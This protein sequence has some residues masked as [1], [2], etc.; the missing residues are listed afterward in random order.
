ML[1]YEWIHKYFCYIYCLNHKNR[2]TRELCQESSYFT[3]QAKPGSSS[4]AAPNWILLL[5]KQ[6]IK[7]S[8]VSTNRNYRSNV[9][10]LTISLGREQQI[11]LGKET[12]MTQTVQLRSGPQSPTLQALGECHSQSPNPVLFDGEVKAFSDKLLECFQLCKHQSLTP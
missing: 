9:W 3:C 2:F 10:K 11:S 1:E 4:Q 8:T 12:Q 6:I 5:W 7:Q